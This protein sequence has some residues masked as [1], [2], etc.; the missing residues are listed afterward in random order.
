LGK[1]YAS[2]GEGKWVRLAGEGFAGISGVRGGAGRE[3]SMIAGLT[4]GLVSLAV[5]RCDR[6]MVVRGWWEVE[7]LR[8]PDMVKN[9]LQR[10][11]PNGRT[12]T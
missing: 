8:R 11:S 10:G 6:F 5:V 7:G 3:E 12:V 1:F 9:H 4:D 2:F